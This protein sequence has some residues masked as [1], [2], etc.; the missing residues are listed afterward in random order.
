ML[1]WVILTPAIHEEPADGLNL[2]KNPRGFSTYKIF[3]F[4]TFPD[5][6]D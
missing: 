5:K 2:G 4:F 3:L 1:L 6:I